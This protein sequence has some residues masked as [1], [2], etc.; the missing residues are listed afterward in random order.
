MIQMYMR[1]KHIV[2]VCRIDIL[3]TQRVKQ[4]G[5]AVID[6]GVDECAVAILNNQVAGIE[7]WPQ[8]IG[9][10]CRYAVFEF[11]DV[12]RLV[13]HEKYLSLGERAMLVTGNIECQRGSEWPC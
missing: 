3:A 9:I 7:P 4:Q 13:A 1:Q 8:I 12:G 6:A 2:D 10:D 5:H 11:G